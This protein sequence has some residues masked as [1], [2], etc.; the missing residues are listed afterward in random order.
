MGETIMNENE[1]NSGK[2]NNII[3]KVKS[4]FF[5]VAVPLRKPVVDDVFDDLP[6]LLRAT[7]TIMYNIL[8]LE[9]SISPK[10]GLRQWVLMNI[11]FLLLLG[12][13]IFIFVPLGTYFTGGVASIAGNLYIATK[14]LRDGAVNILEF[15]FA[16][17]AIVTI[18]WGI[19][20]L[21][22]KQREGG[23]SIGKGRH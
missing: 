4:A 8:C 20:K 12:I 6:A 14:F 1:D 22:S 2:D 18:L 13:P 15:I 23:S 11:S 17:I 3:N 9:Y 5:P 16:V 21:A 19:L 10:G 7:E